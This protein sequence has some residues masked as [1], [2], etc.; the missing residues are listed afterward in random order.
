MLHTRPK[1][2]SIFNT[3]NDMMTEIQCPAKDCEYATDSKRGVSIHFSSQHPDQ[4]YDF[5]SKKEYSCDF[6]DESFKRYE[7][8]TNSNKNIFCSTECKDS[9]ESSDGLD[10]TCSECGDKIHV[11][12]SHIDEVD[13]YEQNNYFCNK[14]CESSFKSREWVGEDHPS[15]DG[16]RKQ[17]YCNECGERYFIKKSKTD[18]SKF[19]SKDCRRKSWK[20]DKE[21]Y[22]CVNCG[23][24]VKKKPYSVKGENT[25]CS[26]KCKKEFMSSIRK[27]E[28]NPCWEGGRFEYYGPN[29]A[30][31]REKALARDSH[32]CQEC[33]MELTEHIEKFDQELHVH[34]KV[35]RRQIIDE[36][37]PTF[38]QFELAN[39][40]DNL[41]TLCNSCHGK[42]E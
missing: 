18:K 4:E 30:E 10:T 13:G 37:E 28:Q 12:P 32:Q 33:G 29:W 39:S 7:Y 16:G 1:V 2:L 15:W 38:E 26:K 23:D 8:R 11:P 19:C 22:N 24:I 41:V 3:N 42:L 35:P 5:S 31:Q 36:D 14:E 6:C 17:L 40:L 27:G 34:H 21:E 25:T 9:F 20:V